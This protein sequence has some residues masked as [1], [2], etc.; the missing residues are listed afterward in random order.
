MNMGKLTQM[1]HLN[2]KYS[3][4]TIIIIIVAAV[5]LLRFININKNPAANNNSLSEGGQPIT[6]A[7]WIFCLPGKNSGIQ[8]V[9]GIEDSGG[10]KYLLVGNSGNPVNPS[11]LTTGAETTVSGNLVTN[12]D[13]Q[14]NYGADGIIRV[15]Q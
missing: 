2:K 5:F 1:I 4:I 13:F 10:K 11:F 15:S 8:C 9:P 6:V 7:G 14:Q 3:M 12:Q